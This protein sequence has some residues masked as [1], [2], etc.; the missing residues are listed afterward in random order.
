MIRAALVAAVLAAVLA[1]ACGGS[2][3]APSSDDASPIAIPGGDIGVPECDRFA[4]K[5]LACLEKVPET[6]RAMTRQAFD[7]TLDLWRVAAEKPERRA[8]LGEAC[9]QY[10]NATRTAMERYDCEWE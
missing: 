3:P 10:E 1:A 2:K 8:G 7:Q 6:T 9:T 4:R 5:Y